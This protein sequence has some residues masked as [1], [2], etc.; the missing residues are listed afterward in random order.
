MASGLL[1]QKVKIAPECD[2]IKK[3]TKKQTV[4][5]IWIRLNKNKKKE[6]KEKYSALIKSFISPRA[7]S[8]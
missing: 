6:R 1:Q 3:K 8:S 7:S 2:M 5:K 4:K